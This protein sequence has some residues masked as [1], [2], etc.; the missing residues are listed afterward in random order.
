MVISG[1]NSF[2]ELTF[3]AL[4]TQSLTHGSSALASINT[5]SLSGFYYCALPACTGADTGLS[6][7]K[8][9]YRLCV[10]W[11]FML[12]ARVCLCVCVHMQV[13]L[14][15]WDTAGQERFRSLIPSYI[16]DSTV[17]VVVYDITSKRKAV[18]CV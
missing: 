12:K 7:W 5:F 18:A 8:C 14:Q 4:I 6:S 17:A 9:T 10:V 1:S 11:Q 2:G 3:L 15:L 16:R 13:R